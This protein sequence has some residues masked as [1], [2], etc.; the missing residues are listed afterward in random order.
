ML[1]NSLQNNLYFKGDAVR[2][3]DLDSLIRR[4]LQNV[5]GKPPYQD[6][7]IKNRI[8]AI[9]DGHMAAG[10]IL[11]KK[12]DEVTK[13]ILTNEA[14]QRIELTD[15]IP[16][17]QLDKADKMTVDADLRR[18]DVPITEGDIEDAYR[19][20]MNK[21]YM[22]MFS[23]QSIYA[24]VPPVQGDINYSNQILDKV[25]Q[26]KID[27]SSLDAYMYK[28]IPLTAGYIEQNLLQK[29]YSIPDIEWKATH[30][31]T[32]EMLS[33]D[34]MDGRQKVD[35]SF[36]DDGLRDRLNKCNKASASGDSSAFLDDAMD[37]MN[38]RIRSEMI[39]KYGDPF[40]DH[41]LSF[42]KN[43]CK[44]HLC[45][46]KDWG[47]ESPGNPT[48]EFNMEI[49]NYVN[50]HAT[51]ESRYSAVLNYIYEKIYKPLAEKVD[52]FSIALSTTGGKII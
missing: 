21:S 11:V 50:T 46:N 47:E 20:R 33:R 15:W 28:D 39:I 12:D 44:N 30:K 9:E 3:D 1:D 51:G 8:R 25:A 41:N 19:E 4:R 26:T 31:I 14:Q 52:N 5:P 17:L 42:Q 29:I 38:Q 2:M 35:E 6:A 43:S 32:Q 16:S 18:K 24:S 27:K 10:D 48:I 34:Y 13:A 45:A 22:M 23:M 7:N 36:F 40:F 49:I 37:T